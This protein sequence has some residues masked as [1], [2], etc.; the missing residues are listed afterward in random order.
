[1]SVVILNVV[2]PKND[3]PITFSW[4]VH[5]FLSGDVRRSRNGEDALENGL[6]PQLGLGQHLVNGDVV[7]AVAFH[8]QS[9]RLNVVLFP[10]MEQRILDTNS[11]EQL[12]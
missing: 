9:R 11:G 12:S 10:G 6:R 5:G 3:P 1:M 7:K 2:A 8:H 4:K